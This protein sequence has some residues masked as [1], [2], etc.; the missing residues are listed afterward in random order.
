M[1]AGLYQFLET[2]GFSHPLHPIV[3]HLPMGLVIGAVIFSLTGFVFKNQQLDK[4][5]FHCVV[6]ALIFM[7]PTLITGALDWAGYQLGSWKE[8]IIIIKIILALLLTGL[9]VTAVM[10]KLKGASSTRMLVIYL[11][12]MACAG[13]L[14]FL[15]GELVYG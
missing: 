3:V 15:G 4:T 7:V 14:G 5:A 11:L 12:C 8:P 6:L 2:M 9:L 13:G 10:A 1:I